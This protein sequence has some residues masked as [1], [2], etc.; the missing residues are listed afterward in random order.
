MTKHWPVRET[1]KIAADAM[2]MC[3]KDL[4]TTVRLNIRLVKEHMKYMIPFGD[5]WM[6]ASNTIKNLEAQL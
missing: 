5:R 3:E 4:H 6:R 1:M 2:D